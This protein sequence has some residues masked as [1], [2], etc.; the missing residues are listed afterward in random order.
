LR[1]NSSS[2]LTAASRAAFVFLWLFLCSFPM[3]KSFEIPGLGYLSKVLGTVA[4][5]AG[6]LAVLI[7][8][9]IRVLTRAHAVLGLFVLWTAL[10]L[11]WSLDPEATAGKAITCVQLLG[12]AWLIW[13]FC[14]QERHVV[15]LM[16]AF[17]FGTVYAAANTLLRYQ[18]AH[19]T[20]YHR[21]AVEGFDPNDF[22]L[23]LALSIPLSYGLALRAKGRMAA[24]YWAQSGL[25]ALAILLSASRTGFLASCVAAA[26]VPL[27][28]AYTRREQKLL[29]VSG[30]IAAGLCLAALVP[31]TS[32]NRLSTIGTEVQSGSIN[33][34]GLIWS[35]GW[36]AYGEHW[37][38]GVGSG[39]Y[40]RSVEP[41]L[42]WPV[43]WLIVA[44]NTF[45]S[46]LVETGIIGFLLFLIFLALLVRAI[47]SM[48]GVSR[49]VWAVTLLVWFV[50]VN[51]LT[52]EIRKPTWMIFALALTQ[53]RFAIPRTLSARRETS[54]AI[55]WT[56]L[57][58]TA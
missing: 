45:F 14:A 29:I 56:E 13:E 47:W 9:R 27:T 50:G 42:G 2:G 26:I 8:G 24:L 12:M 36:K 55:Q 3:E 52:W 53:A 37:F 11:R 4:L 33:N 58:V 19:Q 34:R 15:M 44:H 10:T 48:Q 7:D 6:F 31:A 21:Y 38:A 57:E 40:P 25:V 22:A 5:G 39:A 32:W 51:T 23:T 16:Q 28:F 54:P 49:L 17:V 1:P 35:A 20:Y 18:L 30:A 41:I 43:H 46:I